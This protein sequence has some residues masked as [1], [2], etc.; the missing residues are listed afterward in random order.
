[1]EK[2]ISESVIRRLPIYHRY[3]TELIDDR[4]ERISSSELSR[5]TGFTASQIRQD[6][7]NFGG[8][9][10]QG[11]GYNTQA[12]RDQI[13]KILG[14]DKVYTAVLIGVGHLGTAIASYQG[15]SDSGF[16]IKALFD[17]GEKVGS[18]VDGMEIKPYKELE[19]YL[20]KH[21]IDI[22]IVAV[23]KDVAQDVVDRL[24]KHGIKGIWNFAPLDITTD[25]AVVENVRLKDSL[26]TLG[27]YLKNK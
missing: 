1:M 2:R 10:Q 22:G 7:N 21:P 8:F 4:I 15:F 27:Y 11:Y 6:L 9:G 19:N 3:L 14:I 23:P 13:D 18:E 24:L 17:T 5:L 16:T 25:K 12:L 26:L 20:E